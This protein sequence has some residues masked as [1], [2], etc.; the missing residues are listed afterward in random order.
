M[1]QVAYGPQWFFGF[2]GFIDFTS[3]LVLFLIAGFSL[4]YYRLK[5]AQRNYLYFGVAFMLLGFALLGKLVTDIL[6]HT[7]LTY[8]MEQ[9][10][11]TITRELLQPWHTVVVLSSIAYQGF[12]LYG[13][14]LLFITYEH[15]RGLHLALLAFLLFTVL[16]F[17][18]PAYVIVHLVALVLTLFIAIIYLQRYRENG[19]R[20]TLWLAFGFGTLA[21]SRAL[22]LFVMVHQ[23][24]YAI[25]E[26]VQLIAFLT[27]LA[28]FISVKRHAKEKIPD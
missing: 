7:Q 19:L 8:S 25:A 1:V 11:L 13:L 27:V 18:S 22:F 6:F 15:A 20:V 14:L 23:L 9:G 17:S 12:L 3:V 4:H 28:T 24:Y 2:D 26:V 21:V 5:P 16:A 10:V